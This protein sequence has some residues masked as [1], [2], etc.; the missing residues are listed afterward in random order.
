M[1]SPNIRHSIAFPQQ[2]NN[3]MWQ[4]CAGITKKRTTA[5]HKATAHDGFNI[6]QEAHVIR[7][8][9]S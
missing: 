2:G 5:R 9:A 4:G 7:S 1:G 8:S 3:G 6:L